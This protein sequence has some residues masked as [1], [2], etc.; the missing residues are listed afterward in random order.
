MTHK[1]HYV[2]SLEIEPFLLS[3]LTGSQILSFYY[4]PL[5]SGRVDHMKAGPTST[6]T[7]VARPQAPLALC[8]VNSTD[9]DN[10]VIDSL[11]DL[12]LDY[13]LA[14]AASKARSSDVHIDKIAQ[15][16]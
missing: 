12:F 5:A 4:G 1:S 7:T 14:Q 9:D 6:H 3:N 15:R 8:G 2:N 11:A 13:L 16:S 10:L